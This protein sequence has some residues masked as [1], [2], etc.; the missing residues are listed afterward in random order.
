MLSISLSTVCPPSGPPHF[1]LYGIRNLNN[2]VPP[3]PSPCC[4]V[5]LSPSFSHLLIP[6]L[7]SCFSTLAWLERSDPPPPHHHSSWIPPPAPSRYSTIN[8]PG[9]RGIVY[10]FI[11]LSCFCNYW[12]AEGVIITAPVPPLIRSEDLGPKVCQFLPSNRTCNCNI[13]LFSGLR[14]KHSSGAAPC[15]QDKFAQAA[16]LHVVSDRWVTVPL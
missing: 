9:S 7:L 4:P 12:N 15:V 14:D 3:A 10:V 1:A 6:C 2:P 11:L 8:A 16:C 13:L 5:S